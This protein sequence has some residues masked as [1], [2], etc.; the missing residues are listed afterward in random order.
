M[1]VSAG[2]VSPAWGIQRHAQCPAHAQSPGQDCTGAQRKGIGSGA[3]TGMWVGRAPLPLQTHLCSSRAWVGAG[4]KPECA[5]C[6]LSFKLFLTLRFSDRPCR[7]QN[8]CSLQARCLRD[9]GTWIPGSSPGPSLHVPA[10]PLWRSL[11]SAQMMMDGMGS[12]AIL[13]APL[14]LANTPSPLGP[15]E[16]LAGLGGPAPSR[17]DR[18]SPLRADPGGHAQTDNNL[19]GLPSG[20]RMGGEGLTLISALQLCALHWTPNAVLPFRC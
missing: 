15:T 17:A 10:K 14:H 13:N 6:L 4:R 19:R 16:R 2:Q 7:P 18:L 9:T 1:S 5:S 3:P 20:R 12:D 8:R 11:G